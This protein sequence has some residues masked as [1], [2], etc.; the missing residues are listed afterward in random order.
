MHELV[1]L[2]LVLYKVLL[3][4]ANV[5]LVLF[6]C[7]RCIS[8]AKGSTHRCLF[9][10]TAAC[11]LHFCQKEMHSLTSTSSGAKSACCP[12]MFKTPEALLL[13]YYQLSLCC[14]LKIYLAVS[15]DCTVPGHTHT[16]VWSSNDSD[17]C[18]QQLQCLNDKSVPRLCSVSLFMNLTANLV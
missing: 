6:T 7:Q 17:L 13:H 16:L 12:W 11:S 2:W 4:L 14:H 18:L 15:T 9:P 10:F 1:N 8:A 5:P 3:V